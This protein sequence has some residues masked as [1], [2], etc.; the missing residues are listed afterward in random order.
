MSVKFQDYYKTLG[1]SR[2]AT[3]PEIQKAYRK[4]AKK[5]HPDI[6]K[7]KSAEDQFKKVSE[8]YEVLKSPDSRQKYDT[9]GQNWKTGDT[10]TPPPGWQ[11]SPF[12]FGGQRSD[13]S[14]FSNFFDAIFGQGFGGG[15]GQSRRPQR[16][17]D[18]EGS[19]Q[20]TLNEALTGVQKELNFRIA[21][22]RTHSAVKKV[23]VKIPPGAT[24][25]TRMRFKEQGGSSAHGPNGDLILQISLAKHPTFS[26]SGHNIQCSL[27]ITPWEAALG[28]K[29]EIPT[30]TGKVKM[31]LPAG[32]QSGNIL[33]LKGKGLPI[34]K[35]GL[36]DLLVELK[37]A[38]PKT[39]TDIEKELFE[40]LAEKSTFKPRET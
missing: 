4:L 28:A 6:N 13:G 30:L 7:E 20:I 29:I 5:Y 22:G 18:Q 25:G 35:H 17:E 32:S 10:F 9:L 24:D 27:S 15:S 26:V 8:A 39:L 16:G 11:N 3:Q 37:I 34:K 12:D 14:G 40:S 36:G 31:Q 19:E 33:R 21:D 2:D 38:V 23:N 1:V